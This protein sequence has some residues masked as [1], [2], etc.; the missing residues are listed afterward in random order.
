MTAKI[1]YDKDADAEL[2][3]NRKVAIVGYGSQGHTHAL[4]LRDSGVDVVVGLRES[5]ASR[6]K[7]EADGL[8]VRTVEDA[9]KWADVVMMLAPDTAQPMIYRAFVAPH[10]SES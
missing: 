3:R 8:P 1:R 9:A 7:A 4:N 2:I 10:L 5:S 6:R